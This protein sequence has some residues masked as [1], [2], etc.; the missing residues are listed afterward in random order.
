MKMMKMQLIPDGLWLLYVQAHT[1]YKL[2]GR[3]FR[4][5]GYNFYF[6]FAKR[7][8]MQTAEPVAERVESEINLQRRSAVYHLILR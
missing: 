7:H 8:L 2:W 6:I 3:G 5:C 4:F 1:L